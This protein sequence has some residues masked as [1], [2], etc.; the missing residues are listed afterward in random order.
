MTLHG[1]GARVLPDS[2]HL[3]SERQL[4]GAVEYEVVPAILVGRPLVD[5]QVEGLV[6]APPPTPVASVFEKVFAS[7]YDAPAFALAARYSARV[8]SA[9]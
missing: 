6:A 9:S 4:I 8:C 1:S 3:E 2:R 5:R 7:V